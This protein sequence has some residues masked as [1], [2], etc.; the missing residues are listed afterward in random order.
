M[1]EALLKPRAIKV[2]GEVD[3]AYIYGFLM[4]AVLSGEV[5]PIL[6]MQER[7]VI[8]G[9]RKEIKEPLAVLLRRFSDKE[10]TVLD[11]ATV[12]ASAVR[13]AIRVFEGK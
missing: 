13:G 9:G 5:A 4:G 6:K 12:E 7:R 2:A 8:I 1:N 11:E 3:N 10:I